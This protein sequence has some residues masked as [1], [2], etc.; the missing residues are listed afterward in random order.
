MPTSEWVVPQ[1]KQGLRNLR[2]QVAAQIGVNLT[3]YNG[4]LPARE[5]GRIGGQMVRRM[6]QQAEQQLGGGAAG[7]TGAT[8][9]ATVGGA[10]TVGRT[11]R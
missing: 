6:I 3:G 9:A 8:G 1:A 5:A 7:F 11:T 10:G 2:D 4:D